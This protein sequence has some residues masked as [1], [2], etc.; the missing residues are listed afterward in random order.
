MLKMFLSVYTPTDNDG[1]NDISLHLAC[2]LGL[3]YRQPIVLSFL[4]PAAL[5]SLALAERI[6]IVF[7]QTPNPRTPDASRV[8][9]PR[10]TKEGLSPSIAC[11]L[12]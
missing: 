9:K 6:L 10:Q 4:L 12:S 3:C 11:F 8:M 2:L 1:L 5:A 7:P